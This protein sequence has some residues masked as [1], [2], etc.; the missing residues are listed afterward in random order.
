LEWRPG[1]P[2]FLGIDWLTGSDGPASDSGETS[3][4]DGGDPQRD[5]RYCERS[6][7]RG[8]ARRRRV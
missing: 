1:A 2:A 8:K 4:V 7:V 3:L 5:A 6:V